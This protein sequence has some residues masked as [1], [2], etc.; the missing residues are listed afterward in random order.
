M[1]RSRQR[2]PGGGCDH[3]HPRHNPC[4]EAGPACETHPPRPCVTLLSLSSRLK[5]PS[6]REAHARGSPAPASSVCTSLE[7]ASCSY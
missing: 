5:A 3:A 4:G 6:I 7:L 1:E 2:R